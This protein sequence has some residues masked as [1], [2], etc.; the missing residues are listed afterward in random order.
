LFA[1]TWDREASGCDPN[2]DRRAQENYSLHLLHA[3]RGQDR[4]GKQLAAAEIDYDGDGVIG[5]LDA[6]TRARIASTSIDIPTT[7]SERYLR[8]VQRRGGAID[9][10]ASPEDAAVVA[11]LGARLGLATRSAV[12]DRLRKLGEKLDA[13][14]DKLDAAEQ[15]FDK[16]HAAL[17]AELLGS[18]PVLSDAYHSEFQSTLAENAVEILRVLDESAPGRTYAS[19]D[20]DVDRLD[21]RYV[22]TEVQESVVLRL[23]RA[24]ETLE[25]AT[26][27]AKRSGARYQAYERLRTC[28]RMPP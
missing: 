16:A 11:Q 6:H 27:L 15:V 12:T 9:F 8:D 13:L 21:A 22:K 24:Y 19:A 3:L 28:E 18:F 25:L 5:V 4:D 2:P 23:A 10:A 26:A 17:A 14:D 7:T 20:A 1:G